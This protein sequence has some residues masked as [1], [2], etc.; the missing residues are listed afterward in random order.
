MGIPALI[1]MDAVIR[2]VPGVLGAEESAQTDSFAWDGLL[3][4]PHYTR[5]R[6]YEGFQRRRFCS[7]ATMAR[8]E[9]APEPGDTSD[10][11]KAAI[12]WRRRS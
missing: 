6:E 12:C 2:F 7:P 1:I 4:C 9:V 5:P 10:C 3:D 11:R 8:Y